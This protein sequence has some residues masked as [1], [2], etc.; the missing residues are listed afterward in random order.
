MKESKLKSENSFEKCKTTL[1]NFLLNTDYLP[2]CSKNCRLHIDKEVAEYLVKN[3]HEA[4]LVKDVSY[5]FMVGGIS[6]RVLL[7]FVKERKIFEG[8]VG[9]YKLQVEYGPLSVRM[10]EA[11]PI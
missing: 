8:K 4:F 9:R 10:F 6:E 11:W 2:L 5:G 1:E 7:D 3:N